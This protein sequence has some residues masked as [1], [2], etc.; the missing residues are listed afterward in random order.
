[1]AALSALWRVD[2]TVERW[3]DSLVDLMVA[4]TVPRWAV[5]KAVRTVQ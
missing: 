2:A 4:W 1:M 5:L 3:E